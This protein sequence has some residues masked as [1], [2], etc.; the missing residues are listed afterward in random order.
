LLERWSYFAQCITQIFSISHHKKHVKQ[1]MYTVTICRWFNDKNLWSR[2]LLLM[3]SQVR[4]MWLLIWWSLEVYMVVNFRARVINR[5][6]R[7][8]TRTFMLK[9]KTYIQYR[10]NKLR[11]F[12]NKKSLSFCTS[13]LETRQYIIFIFIIRFNF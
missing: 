12:D 10:P 1:N 7:K 11:E 6:T 9:K 3:W 2:S 8:L 5:D 13:L 4:A